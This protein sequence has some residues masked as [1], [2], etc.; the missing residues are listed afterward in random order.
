MSF[1]SKAEKRQGHSSTF[2]F[3][4]QNEGRKAVNPQDRVDHCSQ[5]FGPQGREV[6]E[7]EVVLFERLL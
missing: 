2:A 1:G 6:D 7:K 3:S 4:L 5:I